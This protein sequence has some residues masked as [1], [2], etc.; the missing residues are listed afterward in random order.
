[1]SNK[2]IA[3]ILKQSGKLLELYG[4]NDFKVKSYTNAAFRI[5][6]FEGNLIDLSDDDILK[7]PGIGKSMGG[8]IRMI[9]EKGTLDEYEEKLKNTPRGV[10]EIMAIKGIG[11]KKTGIIWRDLGIQSPGELLYACNENRLTSLKGFGEKL[12]DKIMKAIEFSMANA[13][14]FHFASVDEVAQI[15]KALFEDEFK[16]GKFLFS[17]DYR[18]NCIV[19][20]SLEVIT[21]LDSKSLIK[22]LDKRLFS[23]V[24][25]ENENQLSFKHIDG[26]LVNFILCDSNQLLREHFLL[27]GSKDHLKQLDQINDLNEV[28]EK[29]TNEEDV[30]SKY[31]LSFIPPEL[32]EGR[33]EVDFALKNPLPKLI[34][35][36][37]LKGS[38]HNH[39][40]YSD[41]IHS[42]RDMAIYC[43]E[44]G[45]EYFGICDHSKSAF[46]AN[47]LQPERVFEQHREIE[48]L[49][50][51]LAPFKIFKGIES[52]ILHDGSLDYD[53]DILQKFDFI[54]A[55]VHS[56][57]SMDIDKATNRLLSAVSNPFTTI[58]GHPTGRLL[59]AREGYPLDHKKVIDACSD[60]NVVIELNAHPYRLDLDWRWIHYAINQGVM[61]SINP[62]AHSTAGFHDM[63]FGVCAGRK[64]WLTAK[65][66]FNA[67]TC[68]EIEA[69]FEQRKA[70]VLSD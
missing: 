52:D 47:G 22:K 36:K 28:I 18:R 60:H 6:R 37:D 15:L 16:N 34:E 10:L 30:Y 56:G 67:L 68:R 29:S 69:H 13:N 4:E 20:D 21:N 19:L 50:I 5:E 62:D 2:E 1:M 64:G 49:N 27:T 11:P 43:K 40:Q 70:S 58:L 57:L 17:G 45:Y 65:D 3:T 38:L 63:Y 46:Y 7:F 25:K 33:G 61:I 39:S 66:T 54:V 51:E 9:I 31:G 44:L 32:R 48:E 23:E 41:G 55:S 42:L 53:A 8:K 35:L 26:L 24:E 59:L 14:K 12:Q